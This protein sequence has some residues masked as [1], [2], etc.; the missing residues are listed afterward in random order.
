MASTAAGYVRMYLNF[1]IEVPTILLLNAVLDNLDGRIQSC[2]ALRL[3]QS[4][5]GHHIVGRSYQVDLGEGWGG[6]YVIC[7]ICTCHSIIAKR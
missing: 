4:S 6:S 3:V 2:Y 7:A 5:G 1:H